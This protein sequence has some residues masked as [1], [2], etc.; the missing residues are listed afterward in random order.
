MLGLQALPELAA[1]FKA[2]ANDSSAAAANE[3]AWA[4][5]LGAW[6]SNLG[7]W[8]QAGLD[9]GGAAAA[10]GATLTCLHAAVAALQLQPLLVQI[11]PVLVKLA[12]PV[13][14]RVAAELSAQLLRVVPLALSMVATPQQVKAVAAASAAGAS[15][16]PE[17]G[18]SA[19]TASLATVLTHLHTQ[20]CRQV[21]FLAGGQAFLVGVP[22][23]A[24]LGHDTHVVF[25]A[26]A[27]QFGLPPVG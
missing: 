9:V 4:F 13:A 6:C 26:A 27:E 2:A 12:D 25:A 24:R 20:L 23:W 14:H 10:P 15:Q 5:T 3:L 7:V 8:L 21:H 22:S 11:N 16:P 19:A 18:C 17:G 1:A